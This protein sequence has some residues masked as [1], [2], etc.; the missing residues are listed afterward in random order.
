[1]KIFVFSFLFFGLTF[2]SSIQV[3]PVAT[4]DINW[5]EQLNLSNIKLYQVNEKIKC[6]SYLD[7]GTLKSKRYRASHYILK[8]RPICKDDAYIPKSNKIKFN[9]GSI[10]IE[11]EGEV[12]RETDS[13]IKIKNLDGKIEKIYKDERGQ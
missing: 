9:F 8:N 10:V 12:I 13:Y 6:K 1:M 4:K 2:A 11:K 5:K 7:I 3:V